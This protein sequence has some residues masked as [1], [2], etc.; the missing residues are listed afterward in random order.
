MTTEFNI[1]QIFLVLKEVVFSFH[2]TRSFLQSMIKFDFKIDSEK[3]NLMQLCFSN[4]A[5]WPL[6]FILLLVRLDPFRSSWH[7]VEI[8]SFDNPVMLFLLNGQFFNMLI[9]FLIFFLAE[10]FLKQEYLLIALVFYFLNR[11]ELHIHLAVVSVLAIYLSRL[12]YLNLFIAD[13]LSL[14]RSIWLAVNRLQ[15][16]A[17]G[18]VAFTTLKALDFIQ[19]NFLFN[20]TNEFNRFNFLCVTILLY[21][22]FS[23]LFLSLWGHFYSL[24]KRE[25]SLL[26]V[27]FSTVNWF[28]RFKISHQLK[29][30]LQNKTIEQLHIHIEN[31]KQFQ[32]LKSENPGLRNFPIEVILN[33]EIA[34]LKKAQAY[35]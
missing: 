18:L 26:P 15:L 27:Y 28:L 22:G 6:F 7:L 34:Y 14:T 8:L 9:F 23:H 17:W 21:T 11:S 30:C 20:E 12:M 13:K 4:L 3:N 1:K 31:Q 29:I 25:P 19:I 32:L 2:P 33:Q 35:F 10:W 16:I 24:K 5:T